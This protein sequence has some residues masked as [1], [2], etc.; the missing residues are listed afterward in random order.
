VNQKETCHLVKKK[1]KRK[2]NIK[3]DLK[4][5]EVKYVDWILVTRVRDYWKAIVSWVMHCG[6]H[7]IREISSPA[8]ELPISQEGLCFLGLG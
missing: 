5:V 1:C 2:D 6:S 4:N 8:E 7:K 3:T